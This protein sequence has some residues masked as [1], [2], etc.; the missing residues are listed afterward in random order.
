MFINSCVVF[1]ASFF[2][3]VILN[4]I[5]LETDLNRRVFRHYAHVQVLVFAGRMSGV[6]LYTFALCIDLNKLE[7]SLRRILAVVGSDGVRLKES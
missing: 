1:L 5:L 7:M 2:F 3:S 6:T 4:H